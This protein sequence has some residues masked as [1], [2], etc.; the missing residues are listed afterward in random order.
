IWVLAR[1]P[2]RPAALG[3]IAVAAGVAG[4][5]LAIGIGRS[6]FGETWGLWSRYALLMWPLVGLAFLVW[7][8]RGGKAGKWVPAAMCIATA[9]FFQANTLLGLS[10]GE[11]VRARQTAIEA[12]ARAR[13]PPEVIAYDP[14]RLGGSGQEERAVRAIPMLRDAG[15]G[16]FAG[17]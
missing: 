4:L 11:A 7:A 6:G 5:A 17:N 16:A 13:L 15:I 10:F 3:L 8:K 1:D 12:D 2:N 14:E 9:M